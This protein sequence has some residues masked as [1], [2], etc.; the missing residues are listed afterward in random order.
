M[1]SMS[2]SMLTLLGTAAAAELAAELAP[3]ALARRLFG[4]FLRAVVVDFEFQ[5]K[6]FFNHLNA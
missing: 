1:G 3:A 5:F 2:C 6:Y 4:A